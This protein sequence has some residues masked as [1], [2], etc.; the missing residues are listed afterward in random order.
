MPTTRMLG[1]L[2]SPPDARTFKLSKYL[3]K[4]RL[5]DAPR[6]VAYSPAVLNHGGYGMLANDELGCCVVAAMMH[7][8]MQQSANDGR[9]LPMPTRDEV[10]AAYSAI[11]GYIPGR[12]ETDIGCNLLAALKYWRNT[13]LTIAGQSHK[14]GA[15]VKVSVQR[16]DEFAAALWLFGSVVTGFWLPTAAQGRKSWTGAPTRI[17]GDWKPGTWGGHAV[18]QADVERRAPLDLYQTVTWGALMPTDQR[19]LQLY[20]DEAYVVL[21][22]DWL[23]EDGLCPA[24][25]DKSTLLADLAALA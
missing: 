16:P 15:F 5:P 18:C 25:F 13:G 19:F 12:P 24:G 3:A 17:K 2:P 8:A 14:I 22:D 20:C 10:V 7:T 21:A 23:G 1:R 6:S 11:S 4:A 9:L